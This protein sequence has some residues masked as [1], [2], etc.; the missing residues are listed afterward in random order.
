MTGNRFAAGLKQSFFLVIAGVIGPLVFSAEPLQVG[1]LVE[2]PVF[3]YKNG[4]KIAMIVNDGQHALVETTF[5]GRP[6]RTMVKVEDLRKID[7][8]EY[9]K[10]LAD[11]PAEPPRRRPPSRL[12]SREPEAP[13]ASE[14]S[15]I[16][17]PPLTT[18]LPGNALQ[19]SSVS[20]SK[21]VPKVG[22]NVI[23]R[24]PDQ[25]T[26]EL[27]PA[28]LHAQWSEPLFIDASRGRVLFTVAQKERE[29]LNTAAILV[30]LETRR[31]VEVAWWKG[32]SLR[33]VACNAER[34]VALMLCDLQD[35]AEQPSL[36]LVTGLAA[37][38]AEV[39]LR[40]TLP[41]ATEKPRTLLRN[42]F[43][44]ASGIAIVQVENKVVAWDLGRKQELWQFD[45]SGGGIASFSSDGRFIAMQDKSQIVVVEVATG[46]L[47]GRLELPTSAPAGLA[48]TPEGQQLAVGQMQTLRVYDLSDWSQLSQFELPAVP[49]HAYGGSAWLDDKHLLLAG[50]M[51]VRPADYLLAW[52]YEGAPWERQTFGSAAYG[53]FAS[54]FRIGYQS[55]LVVARLPHSSVPQQL[56]MDQRQ[57][58]AM[59][60]GQTLR[61]EIDTGGSPMDAA[62]IRL[63][64]EDFTRRVGWVPSSAADATLQVTMERMPP[65]QVE[66]ESF[67]SGPSSFAT[68]E[69]WKM[70]LHLVRAGKEIWKF[71]YMPAAPLATIGDL[72]QQV[73]RNE[74]PDL[75]FLGRIRIQPEI[76]ASGFEKGFG[77][78]RLTASGIEDIAPG[79]SLVDP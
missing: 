46:T 58:L 33:L 75:V 16:E 22:D 17:L 47:F 61:I 78:S 42:A 20:P 52:K 73:T 44:T 53:F 11:A 59:R 9:E 63:A 34:N 72:Q 79:Q 49:H 40:W 43:L 26:I 65:R 36:A 38:K 3:G 10:L 13:A 18:M 35:G 24:G 74:I 7:E 14:K 6:H 39:R 67:R 71:D 25:V 29:T 51:L 64:A 56:A 48:F 15:S 5:Q 30:D 4:G 70:S 62:K 69:P 8:I 68:F 2:T 37:G 19:P 45:D 77:Q 27:P 57:D 66:Y 31:S 28:S 50:G 76:V 54:F 21:P 1:D 12:S 60:R 41:K 23:A 55:T 32:A